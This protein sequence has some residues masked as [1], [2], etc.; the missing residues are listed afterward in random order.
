MIENQDQAVEDYRKGDNSLLDSLIVNHLAVVD[1]IARQYVSPRFTFDELQEYGYFVLVNLIRCAQSRLYDNNLTGFVRCGLRKKLKHYMAREPKLG[2]R[3]RIERVVLPDVVEHDS[4]VVV[5][6]SIFWESVEIS[7]KTPRQRK[8]VELKLQ[9]YE[10]REIADQLGCSTAT[11]QRDWADFA[12][13][14]R[15]LLRNERGCSMN[16]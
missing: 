7:I 3:S 9:D 13:T 8:I 11:A 14:M 1:E 12:E 10:F 16:D 6:R 15:Q 5:D 2:T 4:D